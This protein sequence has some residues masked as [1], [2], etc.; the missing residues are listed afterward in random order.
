MGFD[1]YCSFV[2]HCLVAENPWK[3]FWFKP[4]PSHP[5]PLEIAQSVTH[6]RYTSRLHRTGI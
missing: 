2:A 6:C 3:V 5:T 1:I 4:S